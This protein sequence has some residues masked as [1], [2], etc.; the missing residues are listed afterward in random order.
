MFCCFKLLL[1]EERENISMLTDVPLQH[2]LKHNYLHLRD[3][4]FRHLTSDWTFWFWLISV[5]FSWICQTTFYQYHLT[6]PHIT[7]H[8]LTS[9]HISLTHIRLFSNSECWWYSDPWKAEFSDLT[10]FFLKHKQNQSRVACTHAM[11]AYY[12]NGGFAPLIPICSTKWML[13]VSFT[14]WQLYPWER[15]LVPFEYEARWAK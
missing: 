9:P 7:S 5:S 6:T 4:I 11:K 3:H 10:V 14:P 13:V 1:L 15:P 12:V 8:Y 2:C